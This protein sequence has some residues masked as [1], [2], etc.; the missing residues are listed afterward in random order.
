MDLQAEK[1]IIIEQF[2]QVDDVNL[3]K[4]IKSLLDNAFKKEQGNYDIPEDHQRLVMERFEN[5]RKN[6]E[7]LVDWEEAKK[8]LNVKLGNSR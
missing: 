1:A 2:K 5:A 4:T 7:N 6:P 3:I 8:I